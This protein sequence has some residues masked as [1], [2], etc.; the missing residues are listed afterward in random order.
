MLPIVYSCILAKPATSIRVSVTRFRGISAAWS[1]LVETRFKDAPVST[2]ALYV[3]IVDS[4]S[5]I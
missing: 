3:D 4:G 5:D 1:V 2:N